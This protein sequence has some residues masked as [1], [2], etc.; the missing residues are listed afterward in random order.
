MDKIGTIMHQLLGE[1]GIER[2]VQR[3]QALLLWP[4]VVGKQISDVTEPSRIRK[5]KL[6]VEVKNAAWRNEL[7]FHKD[8]IIQKLNQKLGASVVQEIILI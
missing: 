6:F 3:Y 2:P 1:L 4:E 8:E 7:V 5:G